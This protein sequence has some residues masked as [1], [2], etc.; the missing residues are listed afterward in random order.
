MEGV[1]HFAIF[2]VFRERHSHVVQIALIIL[3]LHRLSLHAEAGLLLVLEHG[4]DQLSHD[5]PFFGLH[6]VY[7]FLAVLVLLP[8]FVQFDSEFVTLFIELS[9]LAIVKLLDIFSL[10]LRLSKL[11][12]KRTA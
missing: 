1:D 5:S 10:I 9:L 8:H 12:L 11:L 3:L 6:L 4:L 7:F 2:A